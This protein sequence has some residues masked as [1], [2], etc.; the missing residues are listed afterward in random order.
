MTEGPV[1]QV[2]AKIEAVGRGWRKEVER[3]RAITPR[4]PVADT[5]EYAAG[6]LETQVQEIRATRYWLTVREYAASLNP[7]VTPQAVRQWIAKGELRADLGS[8]GHYRIALDAVRVRQLKS[9]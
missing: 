2:I 5:L 1:Q 4:D 9:A 3:R 6:E 8:D 7:P